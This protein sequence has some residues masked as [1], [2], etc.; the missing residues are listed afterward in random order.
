MIKRLISLLAAALVGLSVLSATTVCS[1]AESYPRGVLKDYQ[2][3]LSDHEEEEL[4][5]E[6]Q[7]AADEIGVNVGV[8]L[9][10]GLNGMSSSWYTDDFLDRTFGADSDSIVLMLVK[11]GTGGQDWISYTNKAYD[12]YDGLDDNI[13]DAMDI[14]L[15]QEEA[16]YPEAI[17]EF[18]SYIKSHKSGGIHIRLNTV[19]LFGLGI[20]LIIALCTANGV[21][22][23]Y[24]KKA[25]ISARRYLD[26]S[27][28]RFTEKSD[29]FV[30]EYTTSYK[31]SSSSS[32]GGGGRSSGGSRRGGGGGRHR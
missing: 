2:D 13:F 20:S 28:T 9:S 17:R 21:A 11:A 24:K 15:L 10:D 3:A 12:I 29:V 7:S 19:T 8:V 25:P 23:K 26:S 16:N 27:K 18:C 22:A 14:W 31:V 6:I 1:F 4:L 30:R 32:G 5:W